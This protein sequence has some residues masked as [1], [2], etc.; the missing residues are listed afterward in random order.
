MTPTPTA[1]AA[2]NCREDDHIYGWTRFWVP[3]TGTINLSD[4]GFLL[5]PT[6]LAL[7]S[8]VSGPAPL[9]DLSSYRALALLGEPGIGKSTTLKAEVERI[10]A[11]PAET[12]AVSISVDLRAYSSD[13]LLNQKVFE[14]AKFTAWKNGTSH[15]F[16]H[17]DSLDEALLRIETI[18]NFLASEFPHY[19]TERMSVRIACRTAV[20]PASTL[21]YALDIIW[22]KVGRVR[23]RPAPP[24]RRRRRSKETPDRTGT[25]SCA[26]YMRR[27]RC[28]SRSSR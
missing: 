11:Q 26:N 22:G 6:D 8:H 10:A 18:A 17:L 14:S 21:G 15:L 24:S 19:P 5:D 2:P 28:L 23:A 7:R 16:L 20:W 13:V 9:A 3:E 4:G 27:M 12:N 1:N 25:R